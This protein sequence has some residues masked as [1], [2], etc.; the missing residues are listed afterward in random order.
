MYKYYKYVEKNKLLF[1]GGNIA[2]SDDDI[3]T[4]ED[5]IQT[6]KHN[7][8]YEDKLNF[9]LVMITQQIDKL[10]RSKN[11]ADLIN[12]KLLSVNADYV[13]GKLFSMFLKGK[14]VDKYCL[15]KYL[16]DK[17][18]VSNGISKFNFNLSYDNVHISYLQ[19]QNNV[20]SDSNILPYGT[21]ALFNNKYDRI[22]LAQLNSK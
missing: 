22:F 10:W 4:V 21:L 18:Y 6:D 8:Q 3:E 15:S 17:L 16:C 7:C 14:K 5:E 20:I 19:I 2:E 9:S 13:Y 11:K 1:G 12:Y